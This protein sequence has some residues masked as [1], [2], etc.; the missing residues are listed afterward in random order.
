MNFASIAASL[1]GGIRSKGGKE[2]GERGGDR[3]DDVRDCESPNRHRKCDRIAAE[4]CREHGLLLPQPPLRASRGT[5][6]VSLGPHQ[7]S[8]TEARWLFPFLRGLPGSATGSKRV[9]ADDSWLAG[10]AGRHNPFRRPRRVR[11]VWRW[12]CSRR[13]VPRGTSGSCVS[14]SRR[15][16]VRE[17][18]GAAPGAT[19]PAIGR[20]LESRAQHDVFGLQQRSV[21][22][23]Q[24]LSC[25]SAFVHL[26]LVG[27]TWIS[28]KQTIQ[29]TRGAKACS[30]SRSTTTLPAP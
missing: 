19:E 17:D 2:M 18:R 26:H 8:A 24:C 5:V 21:A 27:S 16:N 7:K 12:R 30:M 9:Q 29:Q 13:R 10:G 11:A 6:L 1:F 4:H 3:C 22:T 20:E 28:L 15:S 23:Y 14:R 25:D